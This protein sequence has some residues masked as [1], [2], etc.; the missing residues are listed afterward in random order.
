M[1]TDRG[2]CAIRARALRARRL[3]ALA[4]APFRAHFYAHR[5]RALRDSSPGV[6][7]AAF[8]R[9]QRGARRIGDANRRV[10]GRFP[11]APKKRKI[12]KNQKNEVI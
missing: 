12:Q 2:R 5:S 6:A 8:E 4:I 1:P 7:G 9:L 10:G 11:P 3:S